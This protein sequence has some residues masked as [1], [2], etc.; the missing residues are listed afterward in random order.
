MSGALA[1]EFLPLPLGEG[2]GG[3][4]RRSMKHCA[5]QTPL[6]PIPAFPRKGKAQEGC[7]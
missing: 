4:T 6:A 3:G 5:E 1:F 7:T 2:R